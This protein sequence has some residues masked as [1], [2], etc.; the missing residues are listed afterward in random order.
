MTQ[1]AE[2]RL[3]SAAEAA[4]IGHWVGGQPVAGTSGR[5][6]PVFDPARG[7]A[8]KAVDF[9]SIE[10]VDAAVATAVARMSGSTIR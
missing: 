3:E 8:T 7:V 1:I 9:A 5:S 10:E 2:P 4:R 6:G